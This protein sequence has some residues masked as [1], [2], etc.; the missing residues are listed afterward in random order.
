MILDLDFLFFFYKKKGAKERYMFKKK[1][2]K[3]EIKS[4]V[5]MN[6]AKNR[7]KKYPKNQE[8]QFPCTERQNPRKHKS[9]GPNL[10]LNLDNYQQI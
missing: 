2:K 5:E 9:D 7:Y 8:N 4:Q 3:L 6:P 10:I 1:T